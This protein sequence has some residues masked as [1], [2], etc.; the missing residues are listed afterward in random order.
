[1]PGDI[2]SVPAAPLNDPTQICT[3]VTI[4]DIYRRIDRTLS[5]VF[6]VIPLAL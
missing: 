5:A 2:T 6:R 3:D 1:M 4:L